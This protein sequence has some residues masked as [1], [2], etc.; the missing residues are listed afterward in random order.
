VGRALF[1]HRLYVSVAEVYEDNYSNEVSCVVFTSA[2]MVPSVNDA[3][4]SPIR[5]FLRFISLN[6]QLEQMLYGAVARFP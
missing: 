3:I 4:D 5:Q 1:S 2:D 6:H